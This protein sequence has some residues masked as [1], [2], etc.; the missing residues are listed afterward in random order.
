VFSVPIK[1][2][3]GTDWCEV[4][5]FCISGACRSWVHLWRIP[6]AGILGWR[7]KCCAYLIWHVQAGVSC[8]CSDTGAGCLAALHKVHKIENFFDSDFGICVISLL[9]MHK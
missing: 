7:C 4:C 2:M 3:S 8:T 9:V 5:P 6:G 1:A